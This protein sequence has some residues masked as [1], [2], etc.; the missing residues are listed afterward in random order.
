MMNKYKKGDKFI[1]EIDKVIT[2]GIF[3]IYKIRNTNTLYLFD[4]QLDKL[5]RIKKNSE[6]E[7]VFIEP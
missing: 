1:I 2:D 3:K 6:N 4:S 5:E 7:D